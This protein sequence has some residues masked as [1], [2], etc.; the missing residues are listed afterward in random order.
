MSTD[1]F[2]IRARETFRAVRITP[3][4]I[5]DV[6]RAIN[7][8]GGAGFA[9]AV[10]KD[11]GAITA[12]PLPYLRYRQ[13]DYGYVAKLGEI[14]AILADGVEVFANK[15]MLSYEYEVIT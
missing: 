3:E 11:E 14:V 5:S 10:T 13:G 2:T 8:A 12:G 6:A 9:W 4:N 7:D 1:E 15:H